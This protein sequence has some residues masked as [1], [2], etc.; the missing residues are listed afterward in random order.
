[1][2]MTMSD[3]VSQ[4]QKA[5]SKVDS[6]TQRQLERL[7]EVGKGLMKQSIQ[8]YHA[9][10]TSSMLNSVER[11]RS[12]RYSWEIGPSVEEYP[13]YVAEGTRFMQARPFHRDSAANLANQA[14]FLD[15]PIKIGLD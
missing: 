1:M 10:D 9:V 11:V 4:Y 3:L 6:V 2:S 7:A 12:G 13:V 8:K 14:Q 15:L 5:A